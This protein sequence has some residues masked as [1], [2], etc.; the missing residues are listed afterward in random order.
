MKADVGCH[1]HDAEIP[2]EDTED[3]LERELV[4]KGLQARAGIGSTD[5]CSLVHP[6][7]H[8]AISHAFLIIGT[9]NAEHFHPQMY[10]S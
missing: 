2:K 3:M 8:L 6:C 10:A 9:C 1:V 4:A 5:V 7:A